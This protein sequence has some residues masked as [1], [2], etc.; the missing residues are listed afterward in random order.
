LKAAQEEYNRLVAEVQDSYR[1]A[2][3]RKEEME[4]YGASMERAGSEQRGRREGA[5]REKGEQGGSR[6]GGGREHE[7]LILNKIRHHKQHVAT[8]KEEI[9]E[10]QHQWEQQ[11]TSVHFFSQIPNL[12][13]TSAFPRNPSNSPIFLSRLY[14]IIS[15][16]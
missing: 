5:G 16:S 12:R 10:T 2:L 14:F 7:V 3:H 1:D 11:I 15:C 4:R 6:E 8:L 13:K 9:E